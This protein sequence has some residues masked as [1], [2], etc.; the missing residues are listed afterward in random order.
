LDTLAERFEV[1]LFPEFTLRYGGEESAENRLF[2]SRTSHY[3]GEKM[4][5]M[6]CRF[7]RNLTYVYYK[8][9]R[10]LFQTTN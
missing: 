8:T 2:L 10:N 7:S 4:G 1:S 5:E 9:F 3:F 6:A